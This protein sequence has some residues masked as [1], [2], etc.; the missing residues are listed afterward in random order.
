MSQLQ[1][2]IRSQR[3]LWWN[4]LEILQEK[5][6]EQLS[7]QFISLIQTFSRCLTSWCSLPEERSSIS[8]KRTLQW[9]ISAPLDSSAPISATQLT[10]SWLWCLS[11]VSNLRLKVQQ[12]PCSSIRIASRKSIR[13]QLLSL[14]ENIRRAIWR[15]IT[16]RLRQTS[17]LLTTIDKQLPPAGLTN[18][19][20]LQRGTS[21]TFFVFLRPHTWSSLPL[22]WLPCSQSCSS[23]ILLRTSKESR[24]FKAHFSS[25]QWTFPSTLFRMW[26]WFSQMNDQS[27][28]AKWTTT[29]T[30]RHRIS[31]RKSSQNCLSRY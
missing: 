28:Y 29:C 15:T 10:T 11:K 13:K 8:T 24:M 21:W 16:L 5:M 1:V 2:S 14:T 22:A 12:D 6:G 23:S 3:H 25:S 20:F 30:R 4:R 9:T 17:S 19:V 31:G 18:S 27:S 26:Y 7:V